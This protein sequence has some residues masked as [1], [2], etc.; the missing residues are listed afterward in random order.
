MLLAL[1]ASMG[2]LPTT[3]ELRL[4]VPLEP[5]PWTLPAGFTGNFGGGGPPSV[6]VATGAGPLESVEVPGAAVWLN[7]VMWQGVTED[8]EVDVT[9][10]GAW[11]FFLHAPGL[12]TLEMLQDEQEVWGELA[13]GLPS[14]YV[15]FG[16]VNNA[17]HWQSSRATVRVCRADDVYNVVVRSAQDPYDFNRDGQGDAQDYFDFTEVWLSGGVG[18]DYNEDGVVDSRDYFEWMTRFIAGE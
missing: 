17:R 2:V 10:D 18:A 15:D 6:W 9:I 14:P 12:G 16:P 1:V 8:L 4:Q 11:S 5:S 13:V 3:L 7:V